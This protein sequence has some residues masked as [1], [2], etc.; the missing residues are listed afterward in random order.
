MPLTAS[1]RELK[2][3][4]AEVIR[5][6]LDSGPEGIVITS[7]GN[8]T[9]VRMVREGGP[10]RWVSGAVLNQMRSSLSDTNR[11]ELKSLIENERDNDLLDLSVDPCERQ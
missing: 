1:T 10:Q 5:R 2:Q 3:N 8:P 6:A 4:P 11:R 7:H 9:G